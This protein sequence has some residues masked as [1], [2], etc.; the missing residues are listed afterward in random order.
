MFAKR[1]AL[2]NWFSRDWCANNNHNWDRNV[3]NYD[4]CLCQGCKLQAFSS[5]QNVDVSHKCPQPRTYP[6]FPYLKAT[7]GT[8]KVHISESWC[9]VPCS[10]MLQISYC[11]FKEEGGETH[12]M[13]FFDK[14]KNA[15]TWP[16][17]ELP[18]CQSFVC[19]TTINLISFVGYH[20]AL[21]RN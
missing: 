1:S 9:R 20:R 10:I 14:R 13:K 17:L 8:A 12:G 6:G 16:G 15:I 4:Y 2:E 7:G 19:Y 3:M 11:T 18:T 21:C 5:G